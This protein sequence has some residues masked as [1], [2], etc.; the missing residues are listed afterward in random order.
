MFDMK[1]ISIIFFFFLGCND[2]TNFENIAYGESPVDSIPM[3]DYRS[4]MRNFVI[5]IS[6]YAKSKNPQFAIIPQNGIELVTNSG[7]VS[8]RPVMPYLN[9]IDAHGQENLFYGYD[10]DN[11][12]TPPRTSKYLTSLLQISQKLGNTIFVIDYCNTS[13]KISDAYVRNEKEGF[14]PFVATERSLNVI[15]SGLIQTSFENSLDIENLNQAKNFLFFLNYEKYQFKELVLSE[16]E[17]TNYDVIFIDLF[18]N[19]GEAFNLEDIA[20]LKT[21]ANGALRKVICYMS[22]GEAEDYRFYWKK[23]WNTAPPRWLDEE[24]INW[25]GNYKVRYWDSEW[26]NI[27]FGHS[28]AYL[29]QIIGTGFDGVYMDIIDG[30]EYYENK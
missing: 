15:P 7:E 18:F 4:A 12:A 25:P 30:F 6:E 8:G 17:K 13:N 23:E 27:I 29:D 16:L 9:A 3:Q 5:G 26:Q 20:R 24:N 22:I 14:V 19:D 11:I 28:E 21:K 2:N 1:I 10:G